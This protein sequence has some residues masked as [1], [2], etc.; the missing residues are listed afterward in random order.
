MSDSDQEAQAYEIFRNT[1]GQIRTKAH[2]T[3]MHALCLAMLTRI[4]GMIGRRSLREE[5]SI[6]NFI[7]STPD[8]SSIGYCSRFRID[9]RL[10]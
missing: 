4:T 10:D 5:C 7:L 3:N 8:Q 2:V 6:S 9:S 1:E